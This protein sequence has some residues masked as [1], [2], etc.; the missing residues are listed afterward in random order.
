[1]GLP[2][3]MGAMVSNV[4]RGG[5]ADAAGVR[6][7]DV[8]TNFNGREITHMSDLP[9]LVGDTKPGTRA[10]LE[11]WRKGRTVKVNITVGEM[12]AA[13][14]DQAGPRETPQAAPADALGLT[15]QD[16][17]STLRQQYQFEGGVQVVEAEG[18]AAEAGVAP[19]DIVLTI[20]ETDINSPS[21]YASVVSKLDKSRPA[22]VLVMR[23]DQS[24]W[25]TI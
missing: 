4:E 14:E 18:P 6:S 24:Q 17:S 9:R 3:A 2:K 23:G 1:I 13:E 12:P 20:N 16:V 25:L 7:G 11:L 21:Q 5:P 8:I 10:T 15:V 19:G 22:A